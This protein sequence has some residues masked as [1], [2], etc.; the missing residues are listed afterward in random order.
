MIIFYMFGW[1]VVLAMVVFSIATLTW[2][3]KMPKASAIA[4][5]CRQVNL[6]QGSFKTAVAIESPIY[7][8][9]TVAVA[10]KR[11]G[12]YNM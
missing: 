11:N 6:N 12:T 8:R 10:S 3:I 7:I 1:L 5:A 9:K 2:L 4:K